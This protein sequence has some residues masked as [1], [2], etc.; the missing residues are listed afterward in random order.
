MSNTDLDLDKFHA[1]RIFQDVASQ[2]N[3]SRHI[4]AQTDGRIWKS[5]G[6]IQ[7]YDPKRPKFPAKV[8]HQ[9]GRR[10]AHRRVSR[11]SIA[12]TEENRLYK[13]FG[14]NQAQTY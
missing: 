11:N 2:P 7:S 6:A 5:I 3:Q 9:I 8:V 10:L 1:K 14:E 13:P 12:W 4:K